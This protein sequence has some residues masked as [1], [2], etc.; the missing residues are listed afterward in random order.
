MAASYGLNHFLP[1]YQEPRLAESMHSLTSQYHADFNSWSKSAA[2]AADAAADTFTESVKSSLFNNNFAA[3]LGRGASAAAASGVMNGHHGAGSHGSSG[4]SGVPY[5]SYSSLASSFPSAAAYGQANAH[6]HHHSA[7][8]AA[9]AVGFG[10]QGLLDSAAALQHQ[11][12]QHQA[13]AASLSQC[14]FPDISNMACHSAPIYPWMATA[15]EFM[16][17]I[18]SCR[19]IDA[20]LTT[21]PPNSAGAFLYGLGQVPGN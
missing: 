14:S 15:G 17:M 13:A 6:N 7:S 2:V 5:S 4:S 1:N 20:V 12:L 18:L 3:S 11:A 16:G 9:A 8:A 21:I 19:C 10:G